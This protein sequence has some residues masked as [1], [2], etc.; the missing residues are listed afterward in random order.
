MSHVKPAT[1]AERKFTVTKAEVA[2]RYGVTT[3]TVEN[4]VEAGIFP[5]PKK[6]SRKCVRW[7]LEDIVAH[8]RKLER[9]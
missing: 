8:E 2:E 1:A 7:N 5:R 9:D 4:W 6:M 3:K